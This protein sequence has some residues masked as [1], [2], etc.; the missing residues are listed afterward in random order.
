M[1]TILWVL[2]A[3]MSITFLYS[4]INKSVFSIRTLVDKKGQ[5]GV[6][7]LPLPFVRFI[8]VTEILGAFGLILPLALGIASWLTW[9]TAILFAMIMIP[10]AVIHYKRHEPKNIATN[11]TLF[12]ICVVIALLRHQ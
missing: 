11:V 12:V 8:G 5:T 9:V 4:G 6:E 7:H 10:A 3:L 1:N 2:Q